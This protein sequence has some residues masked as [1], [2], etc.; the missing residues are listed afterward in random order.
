[1]NFLIRYIAP[2]SVTA[3]MVAGMM[4]YDSMILFLIWGWLAVPHLSAP[5]MQYGDAF[6]VCVL[7]EWVRVKFVHIPSESSTERP[8]LANRAFTLLV[9]P[10]LLAFALSRILAVTP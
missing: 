9:L 2:M 5:S 6:A 8:L 3:I 7:I 10:V 4:A 1:M